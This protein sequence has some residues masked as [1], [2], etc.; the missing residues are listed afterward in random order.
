M[1]DAV[2]GIFLNLL[3]FFVIG[4]WP[5][6]W[7]SSSKNR[8]LT[9]LAIAPTT[10]FAITSIASTYLI[11]MDYPVKD[12]SRQYVL[13][14][15]AISVAVLLYCM[16]NNRSESKEFLK[17][18]DLLWL[19]SGFLI[20][21]I[22]VVLPMVVGGFQFTLFRGN[23][24]DSFNYMSMAAYLD[25]VPFSWQN[26][27]LYSDVLLK[28]QSYK[29]ILSNQLLAYRWTTAAML[30]F[31][32]RVANVPI[33][34]FEYSYSILFFIIALGPAFVFARKLKLDNIKAL[35]VALI[36]CAGYWPQSVLD[37]RAFA[38]I[39]S[40]PLMLAICCMFPLTVNQSR[41][42]HAKEPI[43]WGI[44]GASLIFSY[45]EVIP[46]CTLSLFL[47]V[48]VL[49]IKKTLDSGS[50]LYLGKVLFILVLFCLPN[51]HSIVSFMLTQLTYAASTSN[52]WHE[53]YY[54]WLYSDPILGM[55]GLSPFLVLKR[56]FAAQI[57]GV[58]IQL[59]LTLVGGILSGTVLI[60]IVIVMILKRVDHALVIAVSFVCATIIQFLFLFLRQ[61]WWA[62][63]KALAFGYPFLLLLVAVF[64][65]RKQ[66]FSFPPTLI[67]VIKGSIWVWAISQMM[68][69]GARSIN[70]RTQE[71]YVNYVIHNGYYR[72][73]D[74]DL[75]PL[76]RSLNKSKPSTIGIL[77]P[78]STYREYINLV[79]GWD[80]HLFN[81]AEVLNQEDPTRKVDE[82]YAPKFLILDEENCETSNQKVIAS[83]S[84]IA[85]MQIDN[86]E[87]ICF[88]ISNPNGVDIVNNKKFYWLDNQKTLI[89]IQ[90]SFAGIISISG[91]FTMGPSLPEITERELMV[92]S[93]I[94]G[95]SQSFNITVRPGWNAIRIPVSRGNNKIEL[96]VLNEPTIHSFPNGD[97]RVLLL[98]FQNIQIQF[99]N[100]SE[101]K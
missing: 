1:L 83:N 7:L 37:T 11:L 40:I 31:S 24:E 74:F 46:L 61:Q 3:L 10:G 58:V 28:N 76:Q 59:L 92:T 65:W 68:L 50:L 49:F 23:A 90:S 47:F 13:V 53:F 32:S 5:T 51:I 82:Q 8:L 71:E 81:F 19:I 95:K 62:A 55:W 93:V 18:P 30:A 42:E 2:F 86:S 34:Q 26:S 4:F 45:P 25:H 89:D 94:N 66:I 63:G 57:F 96:Y 35:I 75:S 54:P 20:V 73:H 99:Q 79:F 88:N 101:Q 41:I 87:I 22:I 56:L 80:H 36:I 48:F 67:R 12:W 43:L 27:A 44:L 17:E 69:F 78:D 38:Q 100:E 91:H 9:A 29:F 60:V 15:S 39:N 64:G 77:I 72:Q 97:P 98:G 21:A 84:E 6:F 52:N 85:L 16:I 14:G 33:N 70:A